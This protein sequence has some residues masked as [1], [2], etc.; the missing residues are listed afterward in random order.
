MVRI[1]EYSGISGFNFRRGSDRFPQRG[2]DSLIEAVDPGMDGGFLA[3]FPGVF[4]D[5]SSC[6]VAGLG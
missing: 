2:Q 4:D 5:R 3:P 1:C 6:H